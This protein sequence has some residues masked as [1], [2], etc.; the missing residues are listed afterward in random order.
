MVGETVPT[1]WLARCILLDVKGKLRPHDSQKPIRFKAVAEQ[2]GVV[3][4]M[5]ED[6]MIMLDL[7]S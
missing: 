5:P 6:L 1:G 2:D 4:K 7:K 3:K